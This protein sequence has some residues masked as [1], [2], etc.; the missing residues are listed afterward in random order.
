MYMTTTMIIVTVIASIILLL[1]LMLII[2]IIFNACCRSNLR[3]DNNSGIVLPL[4]Q[5]I[6]ILRQYLQIYP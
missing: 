6:Q 5:E 2:Y 3:P 1:L 4:P